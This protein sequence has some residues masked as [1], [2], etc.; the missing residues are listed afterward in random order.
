MT[1]EQ[2]MAI[3]R[4]RHTVKFGGIVQRNADGRDDIAVPTLQYP[5]MA[6][7]LAGQPSQV[8]LFFGERT[9]DMRFYQIGGFLQD[10]F[11]L[12]RRLTIN[13]GIRYDY[14]SVPKE[15]DGRVFN[16]AQPYGFGPL[17]PPSQLYEP[18]T[19]NFA[20]RLGFAYSLDNHQT[21]VLRG[22]FGLFYN[23]HDL[24]GG[25]QE[26]VYDNANLPRRVIFT[27]AQAQQLG[28]VYPIIQE[29]TTSAVE[30]GVISL[31]QAG[32]AVNTYFPSP[33]SMQW[34]MIVERQVRGVLLSAG[35]VGT[36]GIDLNM[37]R[38]MNEPNR[39]TGAQVAGFATFRYYD[40]AGS[41]NYNGLQLTARKQ[42]SHGLA[43]SLN[44]A[45]AR[46][47][48]WGTSDLLL[49]GVPQDNDL[50]AGGEYG[51]TPYDLRHTFTASVVY[52][53][54]LSQSMAGSLLAKQI[55]GGWQVS[56]VIT[57]QT[58]S[59]L[60][61]T[62]NSNYPNSRPNYI[63]GDAILP[64]SEQTRVYLNKAAF[65]LVSAPNGNPIAPGTLGRCAISGPGSWTVDLSLGKT[66]R[67]T[68]R[69]RIQLRADA[70]NSFNHP[71]P[72]G[73]VANLSSGSFGTINSFGFR[74]MQLGGRMNF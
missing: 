13:A 4:G 31:P 37:V 28:I 36:R 9:F 46:T 2:T 11:K 22:G 59:P 71:N 72:G 44:Y 6:A 14:F 24:F 73:I 49:E 57:A 25:L 1:I 50:H 68:E 41:S 29:R 53:L 74:T 33:H 58:G 54:P 61:I 52:E 35:Y 51:R 7:F 10:D 38:M 39:V 32:T 69:M 3:T 42:Y 45:W 23:P 20:P 30:S 27:G 26:V 5:S 12:S 48:G 55:L 65:Q 18:D 63:G 43:F 70:F 15:R 40:T 67:V 16:R 60:N 17:L 19:R 34:T 64:N 47:M 62:Q 21:T 8:T 66:F 56:S